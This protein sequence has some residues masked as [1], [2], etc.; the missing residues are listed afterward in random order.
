VKREAS[1]ALT[2]IER[3]TLAMIHRATYGFSAAFYNHH[4][5]EETSTLGIL[6]SGGTLANITALWIARNSCFGPA[7]GFAG[8]EEEGVTAA[9]RHYHE[10]DPV[11]IGSCLMHY[12]FEKAAGVLG[13]GSNSLIKVPVDQRGRLLVPAL[14]E[15]VA[16]CFRRRRRVI[17]IV[18]IAGTT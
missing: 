2:L 17:A 16:D 18:G 6:A 9:L 8:I 14:R 5:H 13:L 11:I 4:V 10:E 7:S 1:K 12:S 15:I 3:Q